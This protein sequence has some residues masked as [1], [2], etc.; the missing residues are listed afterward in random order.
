MLSES[1]F[2][3]GCYLEMFFRR[4]S[5]VAFLLGHA[6]VP[7]TRSPSACGL[8][9]SKLHSSTQILA[10]QEMAT[11]LIKFWGRSLQLAPSSMH[12]PVIDFLR[13]RK[14]GSLSGYSLSTA[15][16]CLCDILTEHDSDCRRTSEEEP[17]AIFSEVIPS[18]VLSKGGSPL[19]T[20][21]GCGKVMDQP[22]VRRPCQ[23]F[24]HSGDPNRLTVINLS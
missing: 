3:S 21:K 23:L 8:P 18:V 16:I 14:R 6:I 4:T 1:Y 5:V 20:S 22:S 19:D 24:H 15:N 13:L 2:V 17:D 12:P 11:A 9:A 7:S 10:G